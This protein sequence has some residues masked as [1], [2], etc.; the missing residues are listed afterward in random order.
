MITSDRL[1]HI[2]AVARYMKDY[3]LKNGFDEYY[4]KEM[5][6]LGILHDIG[7]EFCE[8]AKHNIVGG[9]LLEKQNYKYA[10]EVKFHGVPNSNYSSLELDLLNCADMH[11][12]GKGNYVTFDERLWDIKNRRG[13]DSDAYKNSKQIISDLISKGYN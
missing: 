12:D 1:N 5:F 10:N 7:Y 11:T 13:E 8:H 6:T 3:C 2:V 4:C 9:E